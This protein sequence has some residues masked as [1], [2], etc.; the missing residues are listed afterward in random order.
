MHY[1]LVYLSS[2]MVVSLVF[3]ITSA[4]FFRVRWYNFHAM[5]HVLFVVAMY[6]DNIFAAAIFA[7]T[8]RDI[9]KG[10][11]ARERASTALSC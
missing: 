8:I 7:C 11:G 9:R 1:A 4:A 3:L 10:K 6:F 5:K 2:E